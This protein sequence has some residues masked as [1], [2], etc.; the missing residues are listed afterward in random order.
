[1]KQII[2]SLILANKAGER[3]RIYRVEGGK[4]EFCIGS[5]DDPAG[6]FTFHAADCDELCNAIRKIVVGD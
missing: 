4:D 2:E 3:L 1:M 6:H 5:A